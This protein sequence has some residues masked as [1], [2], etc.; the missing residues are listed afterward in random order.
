MVLCHCWSQSRPCQSTGVDRGWVCTACVGG[1]ASA[2]VTGRCMYEAMLAPAQASP[3]CTVSPSPRLTEAA[4]RRLESRR[5][6]G[7]L[8]S[9]V[10]SG[11]GAFTSQHAVSGRRR[12]PPWE[13]PVPPRPR[14]SHPS[15]GALPRSTEHGDWQLAVGDGPSS[16]LCTSS[17]LRLGGVVLVSLG[18]LS[19][20]RGPLSALRP[21]SR[22]SLD[23]VLSLS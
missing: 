3:L 6:R 21:S 12:E 8:A 9:A 11:A 16:R 1:A 14:C 7:S 17:C 18:S 4:W 15:P 10:P 5:S 20:G 13:G 23:L 22:P 19:S 2:A